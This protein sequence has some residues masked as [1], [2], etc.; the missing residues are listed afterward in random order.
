MHINDL[1]EKVPF[2]FQIFADV[3][4]NKPRT[5]YVIIYICI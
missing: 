2:R 4:I 5:L 1:E 3:C